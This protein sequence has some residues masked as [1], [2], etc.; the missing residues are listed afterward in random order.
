MTGPDRAQT[1][2]A[3]HVLAAA[4][5]R[6][7]LLHSIVEV[8]RGIFLA[9]AAS[10]ATLE[11]STGDFV[12]EAVAG[13]GAGTLTGARFPAGE[14]I[15]GAV[16]QTGE[17]AI[18]DDLSQD[19]RFAR[20]VA[21]VTGYVPKTMMVA[22]LLRDERTL[23]VLSVLDRGTTGRSTLQELDLLVQFAGQAA[24]ALDMGEAARRA[25]SLLE[26]DP[27][28]V[29]AAVCALAR[30]LETLGG[31]RREAGFALVAALDALLRD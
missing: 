12:F 16:A 3:G 4:G 23:G 2:V 11:T 17:P 15:A 24:V 7:E 18:I 26:D 21:T 27:D 31:H 6:T 30:R 20:D 25:V 8:A 29:L 13:E 10:I 19:P 5:A 1:T 14:G 28:D 22:P 9:H